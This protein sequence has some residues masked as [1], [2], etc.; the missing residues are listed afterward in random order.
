MV[1][2]NRD[3]TGDWSKMN[4]APFYKI[5]WCNLV[6]PKKYK[7]YPVW[8]FSTE[9]GRDIK[10]HGCMKCNIWRRVDGSEGKSAN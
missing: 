3:W 2:I 8:D 4:N 7:I 1:K 6:H 9:S 10:V 5:W